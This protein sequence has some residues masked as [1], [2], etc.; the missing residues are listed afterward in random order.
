[1]ID[2]EEIR[3]YCLAKAGTTECFPFD[4]V[5]LVFKVMGKMFVLMPLDKPEWLFMKCDPERAIEFRE[6]YDGIRPAWHFNKK[7]WNQVSLSGVVEESLVK[8]LIDH[9]YDE[10]VKKL[11]RKVRESLNL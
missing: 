11:P 8:H 5:N 7:Y 6:L 9:S 10:V 2:I 3:L 1:M 4:D